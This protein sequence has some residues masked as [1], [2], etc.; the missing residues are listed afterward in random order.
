LSLR[1]NFGWNLV[2]S[3]SFSL[4]HGLVVVVI[5]RLGSPAE[6]GVFAL[7]L[8]ILSPIQTA[9]MLRLRVVL[10]TDARSQFPF[11]IYMGLRLVMVVVFLL[12]GLVVTLALGL[13][14]EGWMVV[15]FVA[16]AKVFDSISDLL[17]GYLELR[18][19]MNRIAVSR[20]LQGAL[21][22]TALGVTFYFSRSLVWATAAWAAG[23]AAVTLL[24]NLPNARSLL[25]TGA[26]EA[27]ERP[28][29]TLRSR[30]LWSLFVLS[31]PLGLASAV[32]PIVS[33]IPRLVID[34]RLGAVALGTF[35]AV[36][37]F[38]VVLSAL[39]DPLMRAAGPR[40][41][42]YHAAS[43]HRAFRLLLSRMFLLGGAVSLAGVVGSVVLGSW[44]VS[45]VY[46]DEYLAVAGVLPILMGARALGMLSTYF[47]AGI[48]AM[49]VFSLH[50]PIAVA[51]GVTLL[52]L[53]AP[54]A[55]RH[56]LVGVAWA[57]V[58][59]DLVLLTGLG[60]GYLFLRGSRTGDGAN[61]VERAV[62]TR[63]VV[64]GVAS[65]QVYVADALGAV[66]GRGPAD[67]GFYTRYLTAFDQVQVIARVRR[68]RP[69]DTTARRPVSGP[70]VAVCSVPPYS[71]P[72]RFLLAWP[73]VRRDIRAS[74]AGCDALVIRIP[75]Q[76]GRMAWQAAAKRSI[77][78]FAEVVGDPA[79]VFSRGALRHPLR[80]AL[81]WWFAR[82]MRAVCRDVGGIAYVARTPF[83]QRY[84][85]GP[86]TLVV[87]DY[88]SID[89]DDAAFRTNRDYTV[90]GPLQLV[91]IVSL[92][93]RYKRVDLI[94]EAMFRLNQ[95]GIDTS[96]V[97]VGDGRERES[98]ETL[99]QRRGLVD[100]VRFVGQVVGAEKVQQH[101]D[102]ADLFVL[103]SATEG[104]PRVVI[105]AM[106]R[107]M[108]VVA[109]A[110]GGT[111]ELLDPADLVP[112]G[113]ALALA[114]AI[115]RFASSEPARAAAG[116]RNYTR[117][118][119]YHR[120]LLMVRRQAF[121]GELRRLC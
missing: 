99:A 54:L 34:S 71:G 69:G 115:A 105:E 58:G 27:P 52:A 109:T 31:L 63:S 95:R 37:W 113:D 5:A 64:V 89:L 36:D 120:D 41:A 121:Y 4:A 39:S 38:T 110:V 119:S 116:R 14:P 21:Q 83:E 80:P 17:H 61:D 26:E 85:P 82:T 96:L 56:G 79:G 32:G 10:A 47:G 112:P 18:E 30:A 90:A 102:S 13:A 35:V 108:P 91:T 3:L 86:E 62:G 9:V 107:S 24:Y 42:K 106:A 81:R 33:S 98:L 12:V 48:Q 1:S 15:A 49:R 7:A 60:A 70:G 43:Q 29:V 45:R 74:V 22:V 68:A 19:R 23:S 88:S 100:R 50:L 65:E 16:L 53:C 28:F 2:G 118:R 44:V 77:P 101:L 84:P 66:G 97:V 111:P 20:V 72:M 75:G 8:A 103:A 40:L 73:R 76:V 59:A 25:A 55:Q 51:S 46:G 104:L 67:H 87:T 117:S 93:Q 11:S 57:M 92:A 94:L 78:V 114:D 6:V